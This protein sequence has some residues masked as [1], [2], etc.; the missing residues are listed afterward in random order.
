MSDTSSNTTGSTSSAHPVRAQLARLAVP[1][2]AVAASA[3]LVALTSGWWNTWQG[4][5]THQVTNNAYVQAD[6][7][8]LPSR[9]SGVVK[10][11]AVNDF[12]TVVAGQLIA[13]IDP[14]EY[15]ASVDAA[16]AA[17]HSAESILGNLAPQ[18]EWQQALIDQS[19]AQRTSAEARELQTRQEVDR[20]RS[21]IATGMAGTAQ[22]LEQATADHN[23]ALAAV[24]AAIA[25]VAASR[26]QLSV[27]HG[28]R[29][30][31]QAA[32]E[33][34]RANVEAAALKL[35]YTRI[36]A[37]Y[38][39]IVGR[40]GVQLGDYVSPGSPIVAIVPTSGT[41]VVANYKETQLTRVQPGQPATVTVD[42]FPSE[43]LRGRVAS[44]SPASGSTFAL[45]PPDNATGN[46]TKVVQRLAVKITLDEGQA[47]VEKLRPGMSVESN[48]AV[49]D[50]R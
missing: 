16:K 42:M 22:K 27:L 14:A 31:L 15:Q 49:G 1:V 44:V 8:S 6:W 7:S 28:Q 10:R 11:M 23:A 48:I 36:L 45:L 18:E 21:L 24:A 46:F 37:P 33:A 38:A 25:S 9:I 43:T 32:V 5:A 2:L 29:G 30:Q 12:Q 20:Q 34:A 17:L 41:Y 13:E 4:A 50:S 26:L 40:R 19:A 39:G 47:L 35:T 3:G